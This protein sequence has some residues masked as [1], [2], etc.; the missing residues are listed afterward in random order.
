MQIQ[1]DHLATDIR[2]NLFRVL[3]TTMRD[4]KINIAPP[5]LHLLQGGMDKGTGRWGWL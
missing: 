2:G 4:W 3:A 1:D 5:P